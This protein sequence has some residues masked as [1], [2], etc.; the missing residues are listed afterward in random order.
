LQ[1]FQQG[2]DVPQ[3]GLRPLLMFNA[4]R[5]SYMTGINRILQMILSL[6]DALPSPEIVRS[7]LD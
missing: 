4:T 7:Q 3:R 1:V 5:L 6:S 2:R